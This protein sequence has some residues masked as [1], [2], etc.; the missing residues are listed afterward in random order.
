MNEQQVITTGDTVFHKS[1]G[2]GIVKQIAPADGGP[3]ICVKWEK[4]STFWVPVAHVTRV[5]LD[6]KPREEEP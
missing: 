1:L 4:G 3:Q 5:A 2:T 6:D